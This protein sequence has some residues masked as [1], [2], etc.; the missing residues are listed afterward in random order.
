M[1]EFVSD[2]P[3]LAINGSKVTIKEKSSLQSGG[4]VITFRDVQWPEVKFIQ[5]NIIRTSLNFSFYSGE[6]YK[7]INSLEVWG[8]ILPEWNA[9]KITDEVD[10]TWQFVTRGTKW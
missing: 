7:L 9:S 8:S 4:Y 6:V 1:T 3:C 2:R 10:D 5:V